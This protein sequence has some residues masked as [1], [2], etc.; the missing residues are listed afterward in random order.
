MNTDKFFTPI[1]NA[2]VAKTVMERI[3]EALISKALRPGD[4]LPT[5]TEMCES[6][7]VGK[8]SVREAIKMLE[9]LGVV[10]SRQGGGTF[11][12]ASVPESSVNPL[13]YQLL[14]DYGNNGDIFELRATFEPAY[15]VLAMKKATQQDIERIVRVCERFEDK[16][17]KN[18]QTADDDLEFHKAILQATHN[19]FVIRIGSTIMQLFAA[20]ISDS[21]KRIPQQA[22]TDHA[23]ILDAFLKK[24]E[25]ALVRAVY[26]SFEG[27]NSMMNAGSKGTS[28]DDSGKKA[29]A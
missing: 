1:K 5:E 17:R 16:V 22:V 21:M 13:V 12:A 10:E 19:P 27:W 14:I 3:K 8:S 11:I 7:G 18:I 4:K 6:M 25:A 28:P 9:V 2:T 23:H 15:T 24:D 29:G 26:K 20:S